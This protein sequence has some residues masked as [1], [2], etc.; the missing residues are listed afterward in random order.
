MD[1]TYSVTVG[2]DF[3]GSAEVGVG[4][5][6][7]SV[8]SSSDIILVDVLVLVLVVIVVDSVVLLLLNGGSIL[9]VILLVLFILRVVANRSDGVGNGSVSLHLLRGNEVPGDEHPE[10]VPDL[11]HLLVRS[12]TESES[13]VTTA[14]ETTSG[15]LAVSRGT[16]LSS[17]DVELVRLG[18]SSRRRRTKSTGR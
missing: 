8:G 15:G 4:G 14:E 2:S 5:S 9:L 10:V 16:V 7:F 6:V 17:L 13:M 1:R 12:S 11:H 3:D 18:G